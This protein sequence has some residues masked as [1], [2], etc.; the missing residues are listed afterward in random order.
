MKNY[1]NYSSIFFY[2][3]NLEFI[4]F[5]FR[6]IF[7]NKSFHKKKTFFLNLKSGTEIFGI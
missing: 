4:V 1:S 3:R 7:Y 6:E 2:R 5:L